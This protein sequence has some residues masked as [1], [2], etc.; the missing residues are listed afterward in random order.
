MTF[1]FGG[2][3][4]INFSSS[5]TVYI[6]IAVA[7]GLPWRLRWWRICLQSRRPGFDPLHWEDPLEEGMVTH[8]SPWGWQESDKSEQLSTSTFFPQYLWGIGGTGSRTPCKYQNPLM[9]MSYIW[10]TDSQ[11]VESMVGWQRCGPTDIEGQL[12]HNCTTSIHN[13]I[14]L[15]CAMNEQDIQ[16]PKGS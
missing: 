3:I 2:S 9:L 7:I 15:N 5:I 12:Y 14:I 6:W 8:Y 10:S 13:S 16:K 11:L 4:S 1:I